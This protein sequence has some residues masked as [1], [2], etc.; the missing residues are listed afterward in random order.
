MK[1]TNKIFLP[2][3]FKQFR[4]LKQKCELK[5]KKVLI[6]GESSEKIAEKFIDEE[7][8][9]VDVI[10]RDYDS[11]IQSRLNTE[12][13][14]NISIRIN[15]FEST[16]FQEDYFDIVYSQVSISNT[17]RKNSVKEIK[18]ILKPYGIFCISEMTKL[19]SEIPAFV[20]NIFEQSEIQ[21]LLHSEFKEY[22]ISKGFEL[23]YQQDLTSSLTDFYKHVQKELNDFLKS[24]SEKD[25]ILYKKLLNKIS[26]E[27]NAYLKLGAD[28]YIGLN[29][30]ILKNIK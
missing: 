13:N 28:K 14:K 20:K 2:G 1:E 3:G 16:D 11:L 10:V 7:A 12:K 24:S 27:S 15:D 17:N 22:F 29:L 5:H 19:Q 9:S 23:I 26:H 30:L 25:R 18:R 8:E 6:I 21:P 4:I